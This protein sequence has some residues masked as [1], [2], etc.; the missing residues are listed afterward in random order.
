MITAENKAKA[1]AATQTSKEDVGS[2]QVQVSV[3]TARIIEITEHLKVHKQ[4]HK[5]RRGLI[6][7]VG[8]RKRLLSYLE[9]KDFAGYK[10]LITQ[11]GLR[12]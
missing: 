5:A 8:R 12:K 9:K 3:L 2:V 4:D 1:I 7:M 11:L 10:A 6:Q